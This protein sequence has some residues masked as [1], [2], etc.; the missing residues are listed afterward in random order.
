MLANLLD[1]AFTVPIIR[2]K[3][4][5]DPLLG[6]FPVG[7][8]IITTGLGLYIIYL[9]YELGLPRQVLFR[10]GINTLFDVLISSIP[11]VGDIS[12]AFVRS[13]LW[14]VQIM[15]EAYQAQVTTPSNGE[16][17]VTVDIQAEPA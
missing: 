17:F 14:N 11:V 9:G 3:I 12:D 1:S 15:E 2:K 7:G 16:V 13:N 5:L 10:M 4:G 8:D 6:F